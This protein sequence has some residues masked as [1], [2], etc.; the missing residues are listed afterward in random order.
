M[1]RVHVLLA[2]LPAFFL[3]AACGDDGGGHC[4]A[5]RA[6]AFVEPGVVCAETG[7]PCGAEYRV[8]WGTPVT[9]GYEVEV[10]LGDRT[11][12]TSCPG[13]TTVCGATLACDANGFVLDDEPTTGEYSALASYAEEP[14]AWTRWA[15]GGTYAGSAPAFPEI[16]EPNGGGCAPMCVLRAWT[17]S[18][19]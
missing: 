9:G 3:P 19:G 17:T 16:R 7:R 14:L 13:E 8:T 6:P 5:V 18:D 15:D 10:T 4:P 12:R 2:L 11:L 1:N